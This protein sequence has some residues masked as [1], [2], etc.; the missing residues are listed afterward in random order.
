MNAKLRVYIENQIYIL[1]FFKTILI[2]DEY[3]ILLTTNCM[4]FK[5]KYKKVA[6]SFK[7]VPQST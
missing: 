7:P 3:H 6:L 2:Y 4:P 5:T 1:I